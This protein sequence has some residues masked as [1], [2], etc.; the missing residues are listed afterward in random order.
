ML[1]PTRSNNTGIPRVSTNFVENTT[2]TVST[3]KTNNPEYNYN[4]AG[5]P[6]Y[7]VNMYV[8]YVAILATSCGVATN[9]WP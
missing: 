9:I 7:I 6:D 1:V 5:R 3:A 8:P 2:D 4:V